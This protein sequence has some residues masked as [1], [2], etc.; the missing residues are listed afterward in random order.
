MDLTSSVNARLYKYTLM[1]AN[2]YPILL[3]LLYTRS[4]DQKDLGPTLSI[5]GLQI[6]PKLL[7][8]ARTLMSDY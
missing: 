3:G 1:D 2:K 5:F 7:I 8:N 6:G 4:Q